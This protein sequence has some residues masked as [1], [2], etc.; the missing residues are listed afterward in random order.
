MKKTLR[1]AKFH[2]KAALIMTW[3]LTTRRTLNAVKLQQSR[4]SLQNC[5]PKLNILIGKSHQLHLRGYKPPTAAHHAHASSIALFIPR[6][7]ATLDT[8][9]KMLKAHQ[10]G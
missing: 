9:Q 7:T 5:K 2:R 1:K 4:L 8:C 6:S 3:L 10:T